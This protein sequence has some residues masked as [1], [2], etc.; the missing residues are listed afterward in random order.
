MIYYKKPLYKNSAYYQN[1]FLKNTEFVSKHSVS[2]P[3][4]LHDI[5]KT[6]YII[7]KLEK[8]KND[9]NIFFKTQSLC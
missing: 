5:K 3:M 2:L 8:I 7:K 6:Y 1:I 9:K 4:N